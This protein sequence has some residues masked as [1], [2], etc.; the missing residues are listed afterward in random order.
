L[1]VEKLKESTK[2]NYKA[3]IRTLYS[4]YKK[5]AIA[6]EN[7]IM[8]MLEGERY[9]ANEIYRDFKFIIGEWGS[10]PPTRLSREELCVQRSITEE[11]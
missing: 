7:S 8:R 3:V 2:S 5:V 9:K 1:G 10:P 4:K 6:E 11:R